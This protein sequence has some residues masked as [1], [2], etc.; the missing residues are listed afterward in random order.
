MRAYIKG[1]GRYIKRF[2][3][4][5][6]YTPV[7]FGRNKFQF[8]FLPAR[9]RVRL[10]KNLG[11]IEHGEGGGR[12]KL[13]YPLCYSPQLLVLPYRITL[14]ADANVLLYILRLPNTP[15]HYMLMRYVLY[16]K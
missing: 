6:Y 3:Y 7:P 5:H 11:K 9:A 12:N 16:M 2:L 8:A 14:I 15:I 13:L 10:P 1:G 4:T